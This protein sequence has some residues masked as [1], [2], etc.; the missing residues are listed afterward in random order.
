MVGGEGTARFN[1]QQQR[2]I[3]G[4]EVE[5]VRGH[6][7]RFTVHGNA[8]LRLDDGTGWQTSIRPSS[9]HYHHRCRRGAASRSAAA[10]RLFPGII[11]IRTRS[12]GRLVR[13]SLRTTRGLRGIPILSHRA[14]SV[15]RCFLS[16]SAT[17]RYIPQST[18]RPRHQPPPANRRLPPSLLQGSSASALGLNLLL[19]TL[20]AITKFIRKAPAAAIHAAVN[21]F[22][23]CFSCSTPV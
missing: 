8:N 13:L 7:S 2:R 18:I 3:K 21:S 14:L 9:R 11:V 17:G 4:C 22:F 6:R 1:I 10:P 15:S 5:R 12:N 19:L 20:Q 16:P 23:L